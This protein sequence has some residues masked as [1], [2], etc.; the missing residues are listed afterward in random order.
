VKIVQIHPVFVGE[1]SGVDM[2]KPLSPEEIEAIDA[3]MNAHA[4]LVR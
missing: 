3:E 4:V 2:T 1:V